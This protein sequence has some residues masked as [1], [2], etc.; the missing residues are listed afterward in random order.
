[1]DE[2]RRHTAITLGVVIRQA[3]ERAGLLLR[4]VEAI[5]GVS[6]PT[7]NR[8]EHGQIDNPTPDLLHRL[9]EGLELASDDLLRPCRLPVRRKAPEHRALLADTLPF[10]PASRSR[11]GRRAPG[12]LGQV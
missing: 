9:A 7:L 4:H 10:A 12:D 2:S 3:R 11:G 5:T 1:M 6:R 8:L